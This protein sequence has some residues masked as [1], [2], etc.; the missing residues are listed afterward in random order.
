LIKHLGGGAQGDVIVVRRLKEPA[1]KMLLI[2][3]VQKSFDKD[4]YLAA[5]EEAARL[6]KYNHPNIVKVVETFDVAAGHIKLCAI[7]MEYCNGKAI[8]FISLAGDLHTFIKNFGATQKHLPLYLRLMT[9]MLK[10]LLEVHL[11]GHCHRDIKPLNVFLTRGPSNENMDLIAKL[12][13]FG[14]AREGKRPEESKFSYD[15]GTMLYWSPERYDLLH[16]VPKAGYGPPADVF[17]LGMIMFEMLT[18][19]M[20]F[21]ANK[22]DCRGPRGPL[23]DWVDAKIQAV[24]YQMMDVDIY[25]RPT[26]EQA[27]AALTDL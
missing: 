17:G 10:G 21:K 1:D 16:G 25:K 4:D 14:H 13:D 5:K 7:V 3:K 18:K 12:G 15:K 26:C 20:P 6:K 11:Q 23:P 2:V 8:L 22:D 27:L 24:C 9:D 19:E